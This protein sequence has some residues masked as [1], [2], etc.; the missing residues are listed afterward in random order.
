MISA[1]VS[2][3]SFDLE[4]ELDLLGV[5]RKQHIIMLEQVLAPALHTPGASMPLPTIT[6]VGHLS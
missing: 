6:K 1:G 5:N 3:D 2:F 4:G